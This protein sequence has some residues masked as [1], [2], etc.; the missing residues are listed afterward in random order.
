LYEILAERKLL[1]QAIPFA[2]Y[3]RLSNRGRSENGE[4]NWEL[5]ERSMYQYCKSRLKLLSCVPE[6]AERPAL[7]ANAIKSLDVVNSVA[8]QMAE[9]WYIPYEYAQRREVGRYLKTADRSLY[10]QFY[11]LCVLGGWDGPEC[12]PHLAPT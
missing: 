12:G 9:M 6:L 5:V 10:Q 2:L 3:I 8:N 1:L 4:A 7:I 11:E